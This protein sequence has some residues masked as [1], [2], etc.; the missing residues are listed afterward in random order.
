MKCLPGC[1]CRRHTK[2]QESVTKMLATR[3]AKGIESF[4]KCDGTPECTCGRHWE[5]TQ[6]YRD[7]QR[8]RFTGRDI[9]WSKKIADTLRG[10]YQGGIAAGRSITKN[11]YVALTGS[12]H[13][14]AHRGT[15][16]EHRQ[17]LYDVIGP[18]THPCHWCKT[19]VDWDKG[20]RIG[21]LHVDH[22]NNDHQDNRLENLVPSCLSCNWQRQN[23]A[24]M[25]HRGEK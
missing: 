2:S 16:L 3:K 10:T 15:V 23:P 9:T 22:L 21:G 25:K 5:R 6:K 8:D 17:A 1:T 19:P 13:P 4:P 24:H 11:G 12:T 18:G 14:L 20:N 7:Q